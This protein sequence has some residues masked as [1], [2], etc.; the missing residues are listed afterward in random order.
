M[1]ASPSE[2]ITLTEEAASSSTTQADAGG[3][4]PALTV[5]LRKAK[6]RLEKK[7]S[8]TEETVDNEGMGKK[9]SKCCCVYQKPRE[10]GES[11]DSDS[12]TECEHCS[13]HVEA[14]RSRLREGGEEAEGE[15]SP[16]DG[17]CDGDGGGSSGSDAGDPESKRQ[18]ASTPATPPATQQSLS[19]SD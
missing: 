3:S 18:S 9:K 15:T 12:E 11:S 16:P 6:A 10:F 2:T 8:W 13:G 4:P 17:D 5:K 14:G 7:V 19:T 1:A